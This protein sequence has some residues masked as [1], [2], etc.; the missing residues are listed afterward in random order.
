VSGLEAGAQERLLVL[1]R[2]VLAKNSQPVLVAWMQDERVVPSWFRPPHNVSFFLNT[3]RVAWLRPS[4]SGGKRQSV[5]G[6][7]SV[8]FSWLGLR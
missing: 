2:L 5:L 3:E 6:N 4:T 7:S 1:A 8:L